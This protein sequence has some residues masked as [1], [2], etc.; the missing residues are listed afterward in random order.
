MKKYAHCTQK[1][2]DPRPKIATVPIFGT[3]IREEFESIFMYVNEP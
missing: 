3:G 2:I 1:G